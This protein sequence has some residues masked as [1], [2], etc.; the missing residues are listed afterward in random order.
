MNEFCLFYKKMT[1]RA[2]FAK[3]A[4]QAKSESQLSN[5]IDIKAFAGGDK[6]HHYRRSYTKKVAAG[7]IPARIGCP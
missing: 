1:E 6:P 3:L 5:L 2:F 4:T 7:F